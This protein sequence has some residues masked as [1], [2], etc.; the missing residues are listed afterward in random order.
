GYLHKADTIE[1]LAKKMDV[2]SENLANTLASWNRYAAKGVDPTFGR[3]E[4]VAVLQGP[5]YAYQNRDMNI[6]S[7]A[8][9]KVNVDLQVLDNLD[10]PIQGLY[11]IGQNAGGWIGGYYPGSGTALGG[12]LNQGRKV[13]KELAEK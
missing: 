10:N 11:A 6:G 9:L 12:S 7:I 2:S 1:E 8:G 5:F 13:G 3:K 4:G